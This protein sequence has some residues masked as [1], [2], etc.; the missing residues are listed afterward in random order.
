MNS[1]GNDGAIIFFSLGCWQLL[2]DCNITQ[3]HIYSGTKSVHQADWRVEGC[4][5]NQSLIWMALFNPLCCAVRVCTERK[6]DVAMCQSKVQ[7]GQRGGHP[8]PPPPHPHTQPWHSH[9]GVVQ[10]VAAWC[11][12]A[13]D[14]QIK[15]KPQWWKTPEN[16]NISLYS[17][18]WRVGGDIVWQHE[19][20]LQHVRALY[21]PNNRRTINQHYSHVV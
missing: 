14:L 21:S 20:I 12:E 19:L 4:D 1:R 8:P 13:A 16:S 18:Q 9:P 5:T 15:N 2:Y 7:R 11:G 6:I 3:K 17:N 10:R